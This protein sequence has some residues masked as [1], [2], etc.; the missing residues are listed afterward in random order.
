MCVCVCVCVY[1]CVQRVC[2]CVCEFE[3]D[4]L[5]IVIIHI[6]FHSTNFPFNLVQTLF[7]ELLIKI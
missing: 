6:S 2:T 4:L 5:Y 1:A 3:E 7:A